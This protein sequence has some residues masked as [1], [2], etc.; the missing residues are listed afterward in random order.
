MVMANF[1]S[2]LDCKDTWTAGKHHSECIHEGASRRHLHLNW[3]TEYKADGSPQ[4]RWVSCNL[5]L[6]E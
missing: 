5:L 4:P 1:M 6:P 2:H 3:W